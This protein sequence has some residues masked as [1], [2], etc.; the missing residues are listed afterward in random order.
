MF[1]PKLETSRT[2]D[3]AGTGLLRSTMSQDEPIKH[4]NPLM[5]DVAKLFSHPHTHL[6]PFTSGIGPFLFSPPSFLFNSP[7]LSSAAGQQV[8]FVP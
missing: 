4:S 8:R 1:G 6:T 5:A 3:D 2:R 7:V